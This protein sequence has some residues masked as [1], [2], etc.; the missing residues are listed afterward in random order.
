[1]A[2]NHYFNNYT[3]NRN[4]QELINGLIEECVQIWGMDVYYIPISTSI[5]KD[6]MLGD[7]PLKTFEQALLVEVYPE[8]YTEYQG[9]GDFY[10]M[11]GLEIQNDIVITMSSRAFNKYIAKQA[12]ITRPREGDLIYVPQ[13][14]NVGELFEIRY[15]D[16]N[17][18][19]SMFGKV[20]PFKFKMTLEKFR[21]NNETI[22]TGVP[23]IDMIQ[24]EES[25]NQKFW[26]K[27]I[28]GDI[29][30]F[31]NAYQAESGKVYDATCTGI[32]SA[33]NAE[34]N[35]VMLMD[36]TGDFVPD[37][38]IYFDS[39][40]NYATLES[41]NEYELGQKYSN[42][43]DNNIIHK[44]SLNLVDSDN[45]VGLIGRVK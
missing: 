17:S 28:H 11:F 29:S 42:T 7:D 25:Y 14:N 9:Q 16:K 22:D 24:Q 38:K 33:F 19:M 31:D 6:I 44:E 12:G 10:S 3:Y 35:W 20:N 43:Y 34:E 21:Y 8:T 5:D 39:E 2:T 32:V 30:L 23:D 18:D 4:E 41:E 26:L 1:M 27:D 37:A 13:T 15:V 36:I 40:N 45:A